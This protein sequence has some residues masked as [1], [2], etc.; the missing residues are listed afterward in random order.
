MTRD[1]AGVSDRILAPVLVTTLLLLGSIA[2][3]GKHKPKDSDEDVPESG[4]AAPLAE[5]APGF[6]RTP[7]LQSLGTD[8]VLVAWIASADSEPAVDYGTSTT[9]G[10]TALATSQ[11]AR[12]VATLR[13]LTAGTRYFY[14]IRA[15][16]R[17][18][19]SGDGYSFRTDEGRM[20]RAFSFFVTG[21]I[22]DPQGQ[23][24]T[25][26]QAILRAGPRP[27]LGLICG[28]VVY[29][30]G[31]SSDYDRN[32][33][34][35]WSELL[36]SIP[37]WPAL[38]NHDW[39]SDTDANWRQEW[40][41]PNNE[42]YYSFDH[43]N[44]HFVALDTRNGDLYDAENQLQW[45]DRDLGAHKGADWLFVY[46][47]HPGLTCT[48]KGNTAAV[49]DKLLPIFD[50]YHVDVAFCGHA[51]TYERL[52]PIK[53]GQPVDVAQDPNYVD[54]LGTV[55]IVSGAGSKVHTGEPT[56]SCG[57]TA[58]FKDETI[59]WTRVQIDGPRCSIDTFE[60]A[61]DRRVDEV[62]ITKSHL[63]SSGSRQR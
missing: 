47:H 33:M 49:V 6:S 25:T 59:L 43:A 57:P 1:F 63:T 24:R 42:H 55:Y 34:R 18:L 2:E 48:Y 35:P 39:K 13:A 20:D 11:G 4:S 15:G 17:V 9:Y 37:V 5:I 16:K 26:E 53:A 30:K 56:K 51:H 12:H 31:R 32:L 7:Y 27:E 50:R 60:S 45:L 38:G 44:A 23:Q 62:T 54:P 19:A 61:T 40:Y 36:A 28:D 3:A 58:F 10:N 22:G 41:L 29:E 52:Y 14:R 8:S 46:F 21:D